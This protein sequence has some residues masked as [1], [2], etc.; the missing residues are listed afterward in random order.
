M[1][2]AAAVV[3]FLLLP[4][5]CWIFLGLAAV[6]NA[7][8]TNMDP[9]DGMNI[10]MFYADD[11]VY[12]NIG[13]LNPLLKTPNID[14]LADNGVM[15][16][17]NCVTSSICWMSRAT[18]MTGQYSSVHQQ[19]RGDSTGMFEHWNETLYPLLRAAGYDV[20]YVGKW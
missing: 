4:A 6:A 18:M 12:S 2:I 17:H 10:V 16:K 19:I 20:G 15:Y 3:Q 7:Q 9:N 8:G 13:K 14:E 1:K 11:W 5:Q